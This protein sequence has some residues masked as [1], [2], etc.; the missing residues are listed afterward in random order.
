[1]PVAY[2]WKTQIN[3]NAKLPAFAHE[4]PEADHNEIV[5][6]EARRRARRL[7]RDLPRGLAT[8]TRASAQRFELTAE[9][10]EPG[11]QRRDADRDRGRDPH[12]APALGGDARR[13]GL[14]RSSPPAA[15]SI[16]TPVEVIERLKDEL[17]RPE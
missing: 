1:M 16:P 5:G 11:A 12:R 6:W 7:S 4:L 10:I 8:S 3:E 9:L 13:P 14:A 15:A 2:R 17:G